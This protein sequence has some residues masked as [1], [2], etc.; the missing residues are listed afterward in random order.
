MALSI[1]VPETITRTADI[2]VQRTNH[3]KPQITYVNKTN[4]I[5][6]I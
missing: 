4:Q 6:P 2:G 3:K 5:K 1:T